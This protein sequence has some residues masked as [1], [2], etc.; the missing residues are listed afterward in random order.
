MYLLQKKMADVI[1]MSDV[2][3]PDT[4]KG[5]KLKTGGIN[6]SH[7]MPDSKTCKTGWKKMGYESE[8]DCTSYGKKKGK[9]QKG[10]SSVKDE[11][12]MVSKDM[13]NSKNARMRNRL[14]ANVARADSLQRGY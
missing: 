1:G 8:E 14:K 3:T 4:G 13:A 11:K 2:S 12:A 7:N 5:S 9:T 10:S 6:R